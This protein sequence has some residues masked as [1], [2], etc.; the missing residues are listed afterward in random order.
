MTSYGAFWRP[1]AR[2]GGLHVGIGLVAEE[3]RGVS[4]DKRP[5]SYAASCGWFLGLFAYGTGHIQPYGLVE[6]HCLS[7][8]CR[9][10]AV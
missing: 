6:I 9:M 1:M 5:A 4:R 10:A 7:I 2:R 8:T 3:G